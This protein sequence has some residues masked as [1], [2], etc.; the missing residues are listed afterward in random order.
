MPKKGRKGQ[1]A[2]PALVVPAKPDPPKSAWEAF[3]QA[4]W[5]LPTPVR[6]AALAVAIMLTLA[7]AI[8]AL[9]PDTAKELVIA[10]IAAPADADADAGAR[11]RDV[12]AGKQEYLRAKEAFER[13]HIDEASHIV[14][15]ALQ[16]DP[17]LGDAHRLR[18][19][20]L[21][22]LGQLDEAIVEAKIAINI[23]KRDA[24]AYHNL[25]WAL[26]AYGRLAEA[27][28]AYSESLR[29][30]SDAM[31]YNSRGYTRERLGRLVEARA[32]Y[33]QALSIDPA[34][35][36]ALSNMGRVDFKLGHTSDALDW[37]NQ[38]LSKDPNHAEARRLKVNI[39]RA[40]D[41]KVKAGTTSIAQ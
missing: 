19:G 38:A 7:A 39:L 41:E 40:L 8:F 24:G 2:P 12:V 22:T 32:D 16:L 26:D 35:V 15:R 6:I 10:R 36:E 5:R 3:F 27:D 9:L 21:A 29:L 17:R 11:P 20:I 28:R 23:N 13:G 25:G 18:S 14:D 31:T 34:R 1:D 33:K 37:V 4:V 30:Q